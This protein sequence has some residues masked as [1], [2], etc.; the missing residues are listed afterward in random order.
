MS[1]KRFC[2]PLAPIFSI[3]TR[4]R[5]WA[6][7]KGLLKKVRLRIP[8]ISVGNITMGGTGKTPFVHWLIKELLDLRYRPGIVL[9]NYQGSLRHPDWVIT[10]PSSY[11]LYGDEAVLLKLKNPTL[12]VLSGPKKWQSAIKMEKDPNGVNVILVDDGF[13]HHRLHRDLDIVLLD[14]SVAPED[15]FWPPIGR[16][17]ESL[18]G[19]KR[20]QVL[21]YTR[22]EQRNQETVKFLQEHGNFNGLVLYAE[23]ECEAPQW[24]AGRKPEG[25]ESPLTGRGL[26]FCGLGN[27]ES[28]LKTLQ[29][30]GLNIDKFMPFAD[31]AS[32]DRSRIKHLVE[33]GSK[34]DYFVTSEKDM[35]K[36]QDWPFQGPS[37]YVISM[38][39]KVTGALD[40]FRERLVRSLWTNT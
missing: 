31:H 15:Y 7:S 34:F 19:L 17:R 33:L 21:V 1:F 26:A 20:A 4:S 22:W 25:S 39:L 16:A 14:V 32:Y 3:V 23:Q 38:R 11:M 12:P 6:F 28:F 8:V 37:L 40:G 30:Q 2:N 13:Q 36:L 5:N 24:I 35:V 27:P 9:R 18:A 10:E 29:Q